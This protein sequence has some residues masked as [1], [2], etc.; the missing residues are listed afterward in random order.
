[1]EKII[2]I[3]QGRKNKYQYQSIIYDSKE[4]I[5][6]LWYLEELREAGFTGAIFYHPPP[7]VLSS[8]VSY[9]WNKQLKT[10]K[11]L[12]QSQL[13]PGCSYT[14]DF[15]WT[16]ED[17]AEGIFFENIESR[18]KLQPFF[19]SQYDC[20]HVDIKGT[21]SIYKDSREFEAKRKWVWYIYNIYV[22]KVIPENLFKTTFTPE[23]FLVCDALLTR[24]RVIKFEVRELGEFLDGV[25]ERYSKGGNNGNTL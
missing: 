16:W 3:K 6:F 22:Q 10:K 15:W 17:K 1:L 20:S 23:R 13:L 9:S 18:N 14:P 25:K 12:M 4:E 8:P 2:K 24:K 5:W 11:K 19:W 7:R 21:H